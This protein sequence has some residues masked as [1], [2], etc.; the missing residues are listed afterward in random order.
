[1]RTLDSALTAAQLKTSIQPAVKI[2]LTYGETTYTI[3]EDRI[4]DIKGFESPWHYYAKGVVLDNSDKYFNDIDLKGYQA[5]IHRGAV[6]TAGKKYSY[7]APLKVVWQEFDDSPGKL[8][9]ILNML[10]IPDLME[11]DEASDDYLPASDD[12]ATVKELLTAIAGAT[13][14]CYDH[15]TAYTISWDNDEDD[16]DLL[17]FAPADSFRIYVKGS[18]L[19]AFRRVLEYCNCTARFEDDGKIHILIP[20]TSGTDYDYEYSLSSGHPFLNR[21]YRQSLV[22]PNK[23]VVESQKDDDPQYT[24]SAT[25]A[26]SYA[27]LPKVKY[28]RTRLDSNDTATAIAEAL[29]ARAE[30]EAELGT[31]DA[32]MNCGAEVHDYVS[33]ADAIREDKTRTGN[34]GWLE[35]HVNPE[36]GIYH[37]KFGFGA[38]PITRHTKELYSALQAEAGVA[39]DRLY[40]KDAYIENLSIT[41]LDAVWIDPETGY[42]DLSQI[43]DTL[44][45]LPDG[46]T[47]I[48]WKSL[49]LDATGVFLDSNT[50]YHLR[51]PGSAVARVWKSTDA[52]DDPVEGD[53][54]L[55]TNDTPNVVKRYDG[56]D[57]QELPADDVA[58]LER[59]IIIREVK[60]AAL[61]ADGLVLVSELYGGLADMSGDLDDITDGSTYHRV[62]S[63]ALSAEGLVLL[64]QTVEG[65]YGR[66]LSADITAGHVKLSECYGDI[67]DIANGTYG[68][69]L[70]TDISAGHIKLSETVGDL[71]D[72]DNGS[73]YGKLL[74]T[75]LSSGHLK[76][77]TNVSAVGKWYSASGVSINASSG[78][79]IWGT[80]NALTTRATETGTIQCYVGADGKIYAGAGT[81]ALS[82][83]GILVKGAKLTLQDSNGANSANL[84]IN[85]SGQLRCDA[86]TLYTSHLL[87]NPLVVRNIGGAST[88]RY[89]N[90][91]GDAVLTNSPLGSATEGQLKATLGGNNDIQIYSDGAYRNNG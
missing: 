52:P 81:V 13:L 77:T 90:V 80:A 74:L 71:D 11:L 19:A 9:C 40:A 42:V 51:L 17:N 84:Y 27:L 4:K 56:E 53:L 85:T 32:L 72:V 29:L 37:L 46:E 36:R 43:G 28:Y 25:S 58:D 21:A 87:P 67:D 10:G 5:V 12:A 62:Q 83:A 48:K 38:P 75:D 45:N 86:W 26:T 79:N 33:V 35:W 59:G 64:D 34:I 89:G 41:N 39:F 23:I 49:H 47:Y 20:T 70:T 44:D 6:T 18:R 1:M 55:D 15:C 65:T 60:T 69:V 68:K 82:S 73:S 50:F 54:W 63:A 24:G 61:T 66:I 2:V 30:L 8:T 7:G 31:A 57:W 76:L 14:D 91:F 22:I 88:N 3:E 16:D 78:I